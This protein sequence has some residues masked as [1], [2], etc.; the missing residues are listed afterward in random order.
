[1]S[2]FGKRI[3]FACVVAAFA[4]CL[5]LVTAP[6][7][8]QN[9]TF[10]SNLDD[11]N[12]QGGDILGG[13]ARE[14]LAQ[15]FETGNDPNGY[16]LVSV[17][18]LMDRYDSSYN[19]D[20]T[21]HE[22]GS[23]SNPLG[24]QVLSFTKP[25]DP[26][27]TG[28]QEMVFRVANSTPAAARVL[29]A[30][31]TYVVSLRLRSAN[32]NRNIS[33][34]KTSAR[35]TAIENWNIP[36]S[37]YSKTPGNDWQGNSNDL[38]MSVV[39][40]RIGRIVTFHARGA[41]P[42]SEDAIGT[43]QVYATADPPS[44]EAFSVDVQVTA[45]AP[46]TQAHFTLGD[47]TLPV[48]TRTRLNFAAN[49]TESEN[50]IPLVV[51]DDSVY[52]GDRSLT[53][54]GAAATGLSFVPLRVPIEEDES[55]F[56]D[57]ADFTAEPTHNSVF[58]AW[59]PF[60]PAAPDVSFEYRMRTGAT[61]AY[62]NWIAIP[63]STASGANAAGYE[64]TG[65][66]S[67]TNY[68]FALRAT[69]ES[70]SQT[71][72]ELEAS[73]DV[74]EPFTVE[75]T[76]IRPYIAVPSGLP[77]Q[78]PRVDLA[79]SDDLYRDEVF[80][81][82]RTRPV[83]YENGTRADHGTEHGD[84]SEW[85]VAVMPV[86]G[87]RNVTVTLMAPE[88]KTRCTVNE[89]GRSTKIC[90]SDLRPLA[91][92]LSV[93][94]RE[95][96]N[97]RLNLDDS[98]I[99]EN[100]G[101]AT[102]TA[103]LSGEG[104]GSNAQVPF[105]VDVS[106][107]PLGAA[108]AS[109]YAL[110]S[111]TRLSFTASG[112]RSTG[113]VTITALDNSDVDGDRVL[114]LTAVASE[115]N[116]V[117]EGPV[118]LTIEDD[119]EGFG[120][121][122]DLS[123]NPT[124][125][126]LLLTWNPDANAGVAHSHQ[127]RLKQGDAAF[128]NWTDIP[129]SGVGEANHRS[130][131]IAQL[132]EDTQ[133]T[134]Q[135]RAVD[136]ADNA[137]VQTQVV[138]TTL[139]TYTAGFDDPPDYFT[140]G[141]EFEM[142]VEFER[143]LR[144]SSML[145]PGRDKV[146]AE[147]ATHTRTRRENPLS[148]RRYV[149]TFEPD[150][151]VSEAVVKLATADPPHTRCGASEVSRICSSER[152]P[153][154]REISHTLAV[155]TAPATP[156]NLRAQASPSSVRLTWDAPNG[157]PPASTRQVQYQVEN[158][159]FNAWADVE[160][161][162]D[163]GA[164]GT[165]F[166]L[167]GLAN[168]K[169]HTIRV[170]AKNS[171]GTSGYAEVTATPSN[172]APTF[173]AGL[174]S[175]LQVN[176]NTPTSTDIGSPFTATDADSHTL[177]Y[178]LAGDDA[179]SFAIDATTGQLSTDAAL[180]H[181]AK[182]SHSIRVTAGDSHGGTAS[183]A[184][185]ISIVDVDEPPAA[186]AA[187]TLDSRSVT[188][189]TV[190]WTAPANAGRPD[191]Q[192]YDLQY[193]EGGS[194]AFTAGPQDVAGASAE[195]GSLQA[196]TAYEVQVRA[197]N[198]EGDGAWSDSL[199]ASTLDPPVVSITAKS[200]GES[201]TEGT[202]SAAVFTVSRS[203][204]TN[205]TLTVALAVS[206]S[207][208]FI[209]GAVPTSL[210]F[211]AGAATAELSVA[212]ADDEV[213]EGDGSITAAL[214]EGAGYA[215]S[216]T[217]GSAS[218]A[219]ADDDE[220]EAL[221][222]LPSGETALWTGSVTVREIFSNIFG[223]TNLNLPVRHDGT[224]YRI[225]R[226]TNNILTG[227]L[228]LSFRTRP[229]LEASNDWK[230]YVGSGIVLNFS[231]ATPSTG[232][233]SWTDSDK[234][235]AANIPFGDGGIV[236]LRITEA[237]ADDTAPSL[238][239]SGGA[240][241]NGDT[242]TLTYDEALD[243]DSTPAASAYTVTVAGAAV[244]VTGVEVTGS[245]VVL[246]LA[247]AVT[248]GQTVT[249]SYTAPA[250]NPVRDASGN[251]AGALTNQAV[252]NATDENNAPVFVTGLATTLSVAENSRTGTNVGSP[253]TATDADG[254]TLT[255]SLEGA[256]S[257]NFQITNT[258]QL[259]THRHLDYET[260]T[261]HAVTVKVSDGTASATLAVT[262]NITNQNDTGGDT[263]L[264][265]SSNDPPV[266]RKSR[267]TYRVR[268]RGNWDRDVTPDGV[269]PNN[270]HFTTFVGGIHNDQVTFLTAGSTASAGVESMAELGGTA[271]LQAE[272]NA[273]KPDAD[274]AITLANPAITGFR[275]HDGVV[276]TTDHPRITLTS[277]IAPSPDWFVGVSGLSLLDSSGDWRE[278]VAVDLY[279]WDA[280]TEDGT[281]FDL[282][283]SAT[284]PRGTITSI[285]GRGK[286]TGEHIARLR[287]FRQSVELSPE[288]PAGFGAAAGDAQV[289]LNWNVPSA[290][291]ITGHE[292]RYKTDGT[293]GGWTAIPNSAPS[294]A[295]EDSFTVTGLANGTEHTFQL[296]A[297]NSVGGGAASGEVAVTPEAADSNTAATGAPAITGS[298]EVGRALTA[299]KGTIADADGLTR[300]DNGDAGFA[301]TYQWIRIDNGTETNIAGATSSTYTLVAA[302]EGKTIKVRVSFQDDSGNAESRTS[303]ATG[304]I[305]AA[306]T[307]PPSLA[308]SGGAVV[309]GATL[310]L[311][312]DEALDEGSEPAAGAFAVTAGGSSV[313]VSSVDVSGSAVT[314]T[315][316]SAV[317][318]GD[319]VT[320]SYTP[321]T[322]PIQDEA[323]ND[324]AALTGQAVTN[325][326]AD[327]AVPVLSTATVDGATLVLTYDEALDESSEPAAGAFAV[328]AGGSA[329]T[330]SSVAVSG[331][332]VT[333][334]LAA[335]VTPGDTVTLDYTP[336]TSPIQDEAGNDAAA[337]TG[338][339][340]TNATPGVLITPTSLDV[341]EGGSATY[342]V[343]LASRPSGDVTVTPSL[344]S[345]GDGDLTLAST[346]ALTFTASNWSVAQTVRVNAAEDTDTDDG[347]ATVNHAVASTA[348]TDYN[349]LGAPDVALTE[350]DNDTN[351]AA[352]GAPAIS[353]PDS[354]EVGRT[355]TAG[356]GT[357]ADADGLT[358]AD[359]GDAGFA[360]TYQWIRVDN[361]TE[362]DITGA[363][364]GTYTL[365]AADEGKTIKVRASFSDD[366]G[367]AESRTSEAT[368]TIAAADTAPPSLASS[369]GAVVN[370]ASLVLTYDEALDEDSTPAAGA[371]TV[372][373]AGSSVTVSGVSVSG[374]A[375]TLTLA[376]AVSAGDTVTVDYT[377]GADPIQD[378]AGND[379]AA[380]TGQAVTNTTNA[381]ATG[382]PAITGAEEVGRTLTAGKGTIADADGLTKA[383]NGDSGFAYTYQ[384]IRID[385][386]TESDITGATSGT[387]T[388]VAADEGN[389]IKVRVSFQDDAGNTESRTSEATDAI[390][391]ADT[392][393][394]SL[395]TG[396]AVVDGASLVL[397]YDEAL[398]EG[399]TPAV[400]AY[401]VTVAGSSVNVTNVSVSGRAVTLTLA[402]AVAPGQT[403]TVSYTV[404]GTDPLQDARG[405]DA[406]ALTS[407]A[408]TNATPGVLI[409]PTSLDVPEGG[410]ATYSVVLASRPSGDVTV[411]PSLVAGG[412]GDLMLA[413]MTA[414][415]FTA[416][417]WS[418]AQTVRV[419]AAEDTDMDDGTATVNHVVASTED[420]DYN[421]LGAPDVALT[422]TDNDEALSTD[423]ALS[424]LALSGGG[425]A[426]ALDPAFASGT[427][428]YRAWVGS[429]VSSVVVTAT[430][431]DGAATVSIRDDDDTSTADTAT[432]NL[433]AGRNA[434]EVTVTAEDTTTEQTY[435]VVVV[436]EASAP[437]QDSTAL[438]TANVT[439]EENRRYTGD[440][441]G[442]FVLSSTQW[443]RITANQLQI[444]GVQH[445]V[446]AV[447]VNGSNASP[448]LRDDTAVLCFVAP[449]PPDAARN[450]LKLTLGGA[451]F[452][453][454]NARRVPGGGLFSTC[455]DWP[456]GTLA[457]WAW[458]D[459]HL[460][461]ITQVATNAPATGAPAI[462]GVEE[463]GQTL[464]AG[465]GTI[466][467]ADGLTKADNGE[468]GFAYTYQWIRIDNGTEAEI[469]G[470][471]SSTYTLAAAD[472][473][474]TIKVKVSFTDDAGNAESRTSEA[475]GTI[476]AADTAP[477]SLASSGGAVVNGASLVLTYN[478][479]LD[480][481]SEPAA[482][483][484]TV[485]VAGSMVNVTDVAV[486]GSTVT[487]T[488]ASAVSAGDT[489]AVSYTPGT[490]P[491]QDVRG[492]GAAAL[493]S[494]S[495]TNATPGVLITPT[496]LDVP[497]GGSAT[498]SVVLAS[499][500]SA[501]VTVT[502]SLVA[503]GDGDLALAS[504]T[505]LTFTA[506][507]WSVA[508][509]VRVNAAEDT[510][511]DDGTA[512]VNHAVA[513]AD[514]TDYNGLG[515]PDVALTE[516]DNDTNAPATGAPAISGSEK[517]GRTLTAGKGTIADADG[518]TKADN[519]DAGFAYTYQWIRV[520]N[521]TE[522]E[523]A[524]ATSG[525]YTLVAADEGNTIKVRV[526]FQDDSGNAE[527]RTSEATGTIAAADTTAPALTTGG[528]VVNGN[529]LTLTYDEALDEDSTPAAGDF[530]VTAG[531]STVNVTNVTVSGRAVTLTLA[532]AVSA[533][534]TVT[535]SYT[536]GADPI[537]D[538]AGNDAAALS[539]QAVTNATPGVLITPTALDVPEGG[540]ATYSVVLA[541]RP[542]GDVTVTPS[543]ASGGDA[544][545]TLASTTALTFTASN[546]SVAQTVRV[547]A[548]EDAD[549]DDGSAT[550]NHAVASTADT[551]YNGLG[552]PDV[553]LTETDNDTNTP[554]TGAPAISGSEEVGQTL[555]AGKGTITDADGLTKADNGDAGFAYTY[556]WVRVDNGAEAEIAGAT[557][558]TYTLAA[559]DEGDTIK[560]RVNFQD[561]SGNS[562]SRTSEA[563][564][565]IAAADTAPPSLVSSGG[566]VV[567]GASLVLTY[568]EAL[569]E[570][571]TPTASAYTVTVAGSA[572][573]VTDVA[574][575]GSA[576]TLTLAS[577]VSPGQ[578]V[579]V[580][581]TVPGADPIQDT[582][583][584]DAAALTGQAVTNAT[585]GVLI[586]PTSLDVPEGGNASYSVV[587]AS[588]PAGDVTVTP[589]LVSGGDG[590]LA[591]AS[592][593]AL[594]FTA[595]SWSV[596]QTVQVNAA[597]DADM[598]E[599]TATVNHAVAS[600]ADTDYNGL[601]APDVALTETE[602]DSNTAATGAPA[603]SGAEEVG[604]TLTASKGTIA[605]AD[606]LTK[607]DNGDEGFA[608]TYQWIRI[609]GGAEAEIAGA[610]SSNY[611]LAAADEGN[612]IKV[613]VSF[614]D[615]AGN[616]ESR[617]SE[618]TG[619]IAAADTTAPSLTTGG[620]VVNGTTLTLTYDE[621]LDES[622]EPAAG[623]FAVT[624]GGS[625]VTVSSVDVS[626]SAVTLTLASAAASGQTVTL[627]YTPGT[628]PIQDEAGNDAA[629]LTGQAVTNSTADTTAPTLSTAT[630]DGASLVLTYDEA[631]DED[632]TPAA[633]A[634]AVT[635]GGSTVT[636]SSVAVSGSAVTLTLSSAV[637]AGQTVTVSY[638]P[639]ASPIQ[640]EA[641]NDAA[642]LTG[643]AVTNATPGVLITPTSLDV[644]EGGSATYS[645]VLAS[646]PSGDVT[647]TP[648][649]ASGADGDLTLAST[650]ALTFTSGNWSVA[651]T[652]QVNAA[653]D[654]DTDDGTAT[655]N[656]AV[657]STADTDYNGLGAP[658]VALTETDN[659]EALSTDAALSA[660]ALSGGGNAV[661]LTPAFASGTDAYRAWV[662]S[663]VS[664]V[665]V[666]ATKNDGAATVSIRDDDDTSTADT[667]TI[668]LSAG[669]NAIEVTVT[670]E[671]TTTEQTYTVVVVR[672]ASAPAQDPG[673]LLTANVTAGEN[674]GF[675]GY[676]ALSGT[677]W[678]T[679]TANQLQVDGVQHRVGAVSVLGS[680]VPRGMRADT[681]VLCFDGSVPDAA[682][683]TLKLAL[684]G[685]EFLF[686]DARR[687]AAS[688]PFSH[689]YDWPRGT[690]APW[691]WGDVQLVKITQVATNTAATGA[692]A[693]S[694]VEEV[695]QALTAGKGTIAD[696]DGL[697][698]ADNGDAGFAY[699]YQWIRIDSGTE[700][701]ITGATSSTYTLAAADEGN[702]I[703]VKVSFTDDAGNA[704]SRTSEATGTIA[705]ADTT[706]PSLTTGG[707]VVNGTTLTLTYDEA[708]DEDST[709]AAGDFAVTAGG[710]TVNVTNV[711]VSGRAV[712]L[713]LASAVT[714]GQTVTLDYTPGA[715]PVQDEA[716]NDAAAL[717]S[718]AV[719]NNTPAVLI[720][721]TSLDV[722]EGGSATYSVVLASQPSGDVTV[723]PS[724]A[725]GA[726]AD[727]TLASTTALTF[728]SS[729]WS[730]AQTVRVN[731]AEDADMDDGTATVNHVVASTEDTDYNGLGA[732]DV[733]L[734]E[735]DN[736]EA[737][738]TD[739]ALSALALSGGGNAVALDPA[740]ASGTD[741]YRAWVGS[742]VS[743]VVV[744]ATKN[745]GAATVSIRGDDDTSTADTATI[746]L[747]A[748]RNA[749]E[750]TV[751]A[752]D[753]TTEQTYTVVVVREA[754]APAQDSTALLTANVTVGEDLGLC[755]VL[756][757]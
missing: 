324:A 378:E 640:D 239:A 633:G 514:D 206:E 287:F 618:A 174:P 561:D 441:I 634:F 478:E 518:L 226:V 72:A 493:I 488:L 5:A 136:A 15:T 225:T 244:N 65:L 137:S 336:G 13:P 275:D 109:H 337:L 241:V 157:T 391:A 71:S 586:T 184:V 492:N 686:E 276:F 510:D 399:S 293:Y 647:V 729:N 85:Y 169:Q 721:P 230:L 288:A 430:K 418:M 268:I 420:T 740:F 405:N 339:A 91:E 306:D 393:A 362:S 235:G 598:D 349:G 329:V 656:H 567:N 20:F 415:T 196:Q 683:N 360:Y 350:T 10:V 534:R 231:A 422:E 707:A 650:T 654:A 356:T 140:P 575:S 548:A 120:P 160:D 675:A 34:G 135:L 388:L 153:L 25:P 610:M 753:T 374:S 263:S 665:A 463:V 106:V 55:G 115:H 183:V 680:T 158:E 543:L 398:D 201:V 520:D 45:T 639:G 525:T 689:C 73:A 660:L 134:V 175:T 112:T 540:S 542:S 243:E 484:Y 228:A 32:A 126:S 579:T 279:P 555:T 313:T 531:G 653:E 302:D 97:L 66:A 502:P 644:P 327:T 148:N 743:S 351:T 139:L 642:A 746:N 519:G 744:T 224:T 347:T 340:V 102:V 315:L 69:A 643:Q 752:E 600:T 361:G 414:L 77:R 366:A 498:Y 319:T 506:S 625:T 213:D 262:I 436:R 617:T 486:S 657:A 203:L 297:V 74:F 303:E 584:N 672:E 719:T 580:S 154:T 131:T 607:A 11:S 218:V 176:E 355:L 252:T 490:D 725:S 750:A 256:D 673:A 595:S 375:V 473:G 78:N 601:S 42:E 620:A 23:N 111:N 200:G 130:Y 53:V 655:V 237:A 748:G 33:V 505:A 708:L 159:G 695:G 590:D 491:I 132:A 416:S 207:G 294:G 381:S 451:E 291:G 717:T 331:S 326:T 386:G 330:V 310:V 611:T 233:F 284:T 554:A 182:Q 266:A 526:S 79:F 24:N 264:T 372:T 408:V 462:S 370:G 161:S 18:F 359:N 171:Q 705:A 269:P 259:R 511:T 31:T 733:A 737:L 272:V 593:T 697:T 609:D 301:Y 138:E 27:G 479:D 481:S 485:T 221:P 482:T 428:A 475:T 125:E 271:T 389:T 464:T 477:P 149:L 638:T 628:N 118:E 198:D 4:A 476:A 204:Y 216:D 663:G 368:G 434:I 173:N 582:R 390:A 742:G 145:S 687:V 192:H 267:A 101:V 121:P 461:K 754:S 446:G 332:A 487:L 47:Q 300:A 444:D 429:G 467:D 599:G 251:D 602:N 549:M 186:P 240:V 289:T 684:G 524:G 718:Q 86:A 68:G 62:G 658:D 219:V 692:P 82:G 212:I 238:A 308:S 536:P 556:Q 749:I 471:T 651:Q 637:T 559:A 292:Y 280:G 521:G 649:L 323:G 90:S 565:T 589:S 100:G 250:T 75:V 56:G 397:T 615:D 114:R 387:Y 458:G 41:V 394:P 14:R 508:Q 439:A 401:T 450:T 443:G 382:A 116:V 333:L 353:I 572:V 755:R 143:D 629:A 730:M 197:T 685:A 671:D 682:R 60:A 714:A 571:S 257:G 133:Y 357:I 724:L 151:G 369:G 2:A 537:Q 165:G 466:A 507:N 343:E 19:L 585:L 624:A 676:Y 529:T 49:A 208:A 587:L 191:I 574:V 17:S 578:T 373:V 741:A 739:A 396:G 274:R 232:V 403:V 210:T 532:S 320:V 545:L 641:G 454:E 187:P 3:S 551:G 588:Q 517:V 59:D 265:P 98:S 61:G 354:L 318:P 328:T 305:A 195:I 594:T 668:N 681:A 592:T 156:A 608:Y 423:A 358:R 273:A 631:L 258:G 480:T 425:N 541:S 346:T 344:V 715:D 64:V 553:A 37:H 648:S 179:A 50:Q 205:E 745:D 110:S 619:T 652:V 604:Q 21:L 312:Y 630:V 89:A 57:P 152:H 385:N 544:D 245:T 317:S 513:S 177:T 469:A 712:T 432:I 693:I 731:A 747:S 254:D 669:R 58:L 560:V 123:A 704:E 117:P 727:L 105:F 455:Y 470:A 307:A 421:G 83:V 142:T 562:E 295:N 1:M 635:A 530:A 103:T 557:S 146:V 496:S 296:R 679:I 322:N 7:Q 603:I 314:L 431:N 661:A 277:M 338:Q 667:A 723:T 39:G 193:R 261:S 38:R 452:L 384:W 497:E 88:Q 539:S 94:I 474:K 563:T 188:S 489:V 483:A 141:T 459:V 26:S 54:T 427:Y 435:T 457:P 735:T 364:S 365:V 383:D 211:A 738:S 659:D 413:S 162:A 29:A 185:T 456:R 283:N 166:T 552:A 367:N 688:G 445:R 363:T 605:D 170:R 80:R 46:A 404:P 558:S 163:G 12:D 395:T 702:T 22:F 509:T 28:Y 87:A 270:P 40:Q 417:N 167:T 99:A 36:N 30:N 352:T 410:N 242:L 223:D 199:S 84:R 51:H 596:A 96:V 107:E 523:I 694:G 710:S 494:Q 535:V 402:S 449:G 616:A 299:G 438:L 119:E 696:A 278:D 499:R 726:D 345:G 613:K 570:G 732:P 248:A 281:E 380:L 253:F 16:R 246:T 150:A 348:D 341:P 407:Q 460:L 249:V 194:G 227:R 113:E 172:N 286:F 8:A 636:V 606:G 181:E 501:D 155:L 645:V 290:T 260:R 627:D 564:G 591:L 342:S 325:N 716:G 189:L 424:A 597:E 550:V 736:D 63:D 528:A 547:N 104:L 247:S 632:S 573:S 720:T 522:A 234:L 426:V 621:A 538:E 583:G 495:V 379:A 217:A 581:Y 666:T 376:S 448:G 664:S 400:G 220:P 500:P 215:V 411:T 124:Y 612:T 377:P 95:Q 298:E 527:S 699:T 453:F 568:D 700:S 713:T 122:A 646:Q 67:N 546:W 93:T 412:D 178:A 515:A 701:D 222:D 304:T 419:N 626:G 734:T 437:A 70:G 180:D 447:S 756:R 214:S 442:Y 662:G 516:T 709:P 468:S 433:S 282:S 576:V 392:T 711:T 9:I 209:D 168:D 465:T 81:P 236:N 164:N 623:D 285:R 703:K 6:A 728:T 706:A 751:T 202:D 147:G 409:T 722:P 677:P 334:T 48:A 311:T 108:T 316:A 309:N 190:E 614:T 577:A 144:T 35:D 129:D 229:S 512:T 757:S 569:N 92:G 691:A 472:E 335:A 678:G 321:G 371:F 127:Y 52:S 406:A 504:T 255:Y 44:D 503:G 533:G 670:A 690:L 674:L 128:G 440:F 566:A 698:K 622:S 76:A 43:V